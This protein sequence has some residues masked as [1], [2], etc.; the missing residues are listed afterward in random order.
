MKCGPRMERRW[1]AR[2]G[3]REYPEKARRQAVL[4]STIPTCE[5]PGA[6][7]PGIEPGW[8]WWEANDRRPTG[9]AEYGTASAPIP[10][11]F[12]DIQGHEHGIEV[13]DTGQ[14]H[15]HP[16]WP[17]TDRNVKTC[18]IVIVEV[19]L[20]PMFGDWLW[21]GPYVRLATVRCG[22]CSI[23][24]P[25][26]EL[27]E[28][29]VFRGL[30]SHQA[31]LR[32]PLYARDTIVCLLVTA[33]NN[34]WAKSWDVYIRKAARV[35]AEL[36]NLEKKKKKKR[37]FEM[38]REDLEK[39]PGLNTRPGHRIFASGCCVGRCRWSAGF[40]RDLPFSPPLHSGAYP[41]SPSCTLIGS[42]DLDV[43]RAAKISPLDSTPFRLCV[44]ICSYRY[45]HGTATTLRTIRRSRIMGG[46]G[47]VDVCS[48]VC[49]E[50]GGGMVWEG[51]E[52]AGAR[53]SRDIN[54]S[55]G[56]AVMR[57]LRDAIWPARATAPPWALVLRHSS[58]SWGFLIYRLPSFIISF[59]H[60]SSPIVQPASR[61]LHCLILAV[62]DFP[63][64]CHFSRYS[65]S[66]AWN[67][68][69]HSLINSNST[70]SPEA[71][72]NI[73]TFA[74]NIWKVQRTPSRAERMR[75]VIQSILQINA[76]INTTRVSSMLHKRAFRVGLPF[77]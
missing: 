9:M 21:N 27:V 14:G 70:P 23:F 37:E 39:R 52:A 33:I 61:T 38:M 54:Q 26:D 73:Y 29:Q 59:T 65:Y 67:S 64:T 75:S 57:H 1:N 60:T 44:L 43:K 22:R 63:S 49:L 36:E 20:I 34:Q 35:A 68:A 66:I 62:A 30:I 77:L 45:F 74:M 40:L 51:R 6:D 69:T 46:R 18:Q 47:S 13:K 32:S 17:L 31:R 5:D 4:S 2:T 7:Q 76:E 12:N 24:R 16:R 15:Q 25:A 41:F 53:V 50:G 71:C 19:T 56:A 10:D 3:K 58:W 55:V 28:L 48:G 72:R 11:P 8:P 42:Q